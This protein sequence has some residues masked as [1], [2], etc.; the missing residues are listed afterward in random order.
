MATI[1]INVKLNSAFQLLKK[2]ED[3]TGKTLKNPKL[4]RE[5]VRILKTKAPFQ[6]GRLRRSI[7]VIRKHGFIR[8]IGMLKYGWYLEKGTKPHLI[9]PVHAKTLHFWTT[10]GEEIFAKR[11]NHP[12]ITPTRWISI[13][14]KEIRDRLRYWL[15]QLITQNLKM[16]V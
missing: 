12:G 9:Y 14:T 11:V 16:E 13:G 2:L 5:T 4:E 10:T 7:K 3:K 6:T 1:L 15:K 8:E